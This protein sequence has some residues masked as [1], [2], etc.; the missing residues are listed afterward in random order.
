MG[1]GS[2]HQPRCPNPE[3][4]EPPTWSGRHH[5]LWESPSP[6]AHRTRLG[7]LERPSGTQRPGWESPC[8]HQYSHT[9]HCGA[10]LP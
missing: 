4:R 7:T 2:P 5:R 9:L 10:G 3:H 1:T 8:E 6:S